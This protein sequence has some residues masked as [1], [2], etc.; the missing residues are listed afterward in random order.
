MKKVTHICFAILTCG[1]LLNL[2]VEAGERPNVLFICIDDLNDW[3]GCLGGYPGPSHTPHIDELADDGVLFTRAY[4]SSPMC[5]PSRVALWTGKRASTTGCYGQYVQWDDARVETTTLMQWFNDDG[6]RLI[7]GGKIF[8]HGKEVHD[9]PAFDDLRSFYHSGYSKNA[10][11]AGKMRYGATH[12][13]DEQMHDHQLVDWCIER[14]EKKSEQPFFMVA[15]LFRPHAP[16][17]CPKNIWTFIP[18]MKLLS[19][20]SQLAR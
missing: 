15:G 20:R 14:L 18:L 7:G 1:W 19:R 10:K 17:G 11:I 2:Q 6:Y 13:G 4:P 5:N 12:Y 8:H 9:D 16:I 3:V